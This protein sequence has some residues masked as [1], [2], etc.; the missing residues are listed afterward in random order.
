MSRRQKEDQVTTT[1]EKEDDTDST[2]TVTTAAFTSVCE[3]G[4]DDDITEQPA[5][6]TTLNNQIYS[7]IGRPIR[8][9]IKLICQRTRR[10]T[11]LLRPPLESS[12]RGEFRSSGSIFV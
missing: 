11:T 7:W 2:A 12:R 1:A 9:D 5:E 4:W 8:A 6:T 3:S 10:A